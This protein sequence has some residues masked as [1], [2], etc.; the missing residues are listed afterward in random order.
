MQRAT[1]LQSYE[2]RDGCVC[3]K[4]SQSKSGAEAASH[5]R[6]T[7]CFLPAPFSSCREKINLLITLPH[8]IVR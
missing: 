7:H 3:K 5:S 2:H 8:N 6:L 1:T 4:W